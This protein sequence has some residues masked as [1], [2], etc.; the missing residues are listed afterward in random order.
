VRVCPDLIYDVGVCHGDDSAYYLHKGYRVVGI[1]PHPGLVERLRERFEGEISEGRYILVESAIAEHAGEAQFWICDDVPGWSSFD[2]EIAGYDGSRCHQVSVSTTRFEH[3][4]EQFG[5]PVFCKIDIEG[6]DA[7][8]LEALSVDTRPQFLS[9]E[10]P[11]IGTGVVRGKG[12]EDYIRRLEKL[13]Y[14]RFKII[15][16]VTFRQPGKILAWI[17][18]QLPRYASWRITRLQR[19]IMMRRSDGDW[20]F[21]DEASGPF[22][23]E[24]GGK[25]LN[26]ADAIALARLL[27]SNDDFSDWFDIHATVAA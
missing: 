15:S 7:F 22:G 18:A 13:G 17:K 14:S 5:V 11:V 1:E 9:V 21:S 24:T 4:L 19:L 6:S 23:E 10:I 12:G 8:C 27:E 20:T 16:Q 2:P 3:V 26:S 25:W